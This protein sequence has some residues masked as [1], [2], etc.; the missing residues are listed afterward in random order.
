MTCAWQIGQRFRW[1][2][3]SWIGAGGLFLL[4]ACDTLPVLTETVFPGMAEAPPTG[5]VYFVT[6]RAPDNGA[7][8]AYGHDRSA[9]MA[10][11][12]AVLGFDK[13]AV[14]VDDRAIRVRDVSE[15]VRFPATPLPFFHRSGAS[16][17]DSVKWSAYQAATREFQAQVAQALRAAQVDEVVVFVHGYR[18]DFDDALTTTANIWQAADRSVVPIAY[19]WP[20][21]NPG[22]F[23]YFK[24]RESGEFS[25]FHLKETLR[26]LAGVREVRNIHVVAHSRGTD[27]ATAALREMI[28]AARAAGKNPRQVLKI[29]NLVL[30]AP[31]LDFDVVRQRLIAEKFGPAFGNIT[32][33]MNPSDGA[34]G[35]AQT[36]NSGTR[37]GR[38]SYADLNPADR[39]ILSQVD[40]VHFVDVSGVVSP[41]GHSYFREN[42]VVLTDIVM[43]LQFD[44]APGSPERSLS[45]VAANFWMLEQ[46][47][48]DTFEPADR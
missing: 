5:Q 21:D 24:D 22:L 41:R 29:D 23:G 8:S 15:Q 36:V 19:T 9:S 4:S 42:P 13:L 32:V 30:A 11:G 1:R 25:I 34:L 48:V 6:D 47:S 40:N 2:V 16:E 20:A 17:S 3:P 37:F 38:L 33:Y 26:I 43:L 7:D 35:F 44:A 14:D 10:F 45:H 46:F 31:D 39:R 18:N 28:I 12:R 27:V